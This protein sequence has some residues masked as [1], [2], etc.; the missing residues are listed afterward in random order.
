[1]AEFAKW[2]SGNPQGP[3]RLRVGGSVSESVGLS[4]SPVGPRTVPSIK[5]FV[6]LFTR[7][8][9]A[10]L[11]VVTLACLAIILPSAKCLQTETLSSA[12]VEVNGA[13]SR[14]RV[15][16]AATARLQRAAKKAKSL[17]A[18]L[19]IDTLSRAAAALSTEQFFDES[20]ATRQELISV[21]RR[22]GGSEDPVGSG[23]LRNVVALAADLKSSQRFDDA[24][25]V[26][27]SV[28]QEVELS[29]AGV[30]DPSTRAAAASLLLK[31]RSVGRRGESRARTPPAAA[32]APASCVSGGVSDAGLCG[33][34]P[35]GAGPPDARR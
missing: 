21:L 6:A 3:S 26:V 14:S 24:L 23:L 27:R 11:A 8:M 16:S 35:D 10:I 4:R 2:C 22:S 1:M 13:I 20:V 9:P 15:P 30:A 18:A 31:V 12:Q 33:G 19:Q 17:P 5:D 7:A 25:A 32:A 29:S 28:Q 34:R